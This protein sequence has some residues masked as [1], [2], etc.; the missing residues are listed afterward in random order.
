MVFSSILF[1]FF[2]LSALLVCYFLLPARWRKGR[3]LVLLAFSLGFY[4][5]AGVR[6]VPLILGSILCD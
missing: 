6:A 3:N 5:C 2:F 1:L 4:A